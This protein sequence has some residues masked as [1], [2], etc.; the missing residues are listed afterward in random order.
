MRCMRP[1]LV[2]RSHLNLPNLRTFY[3]AKASTFRLNAFGTLSMSSQS[4]P[5]ALTFE[6]KGRCSVSAPIHQ[7]RGSFSDK[8][9]NIDKQSPG[10]G[11]S[12]ASWT[13][14]VTH[15]HASS[16]TRLSQRPHSGA[17]GRYKL[18]TMSQQHLSPWPQARS[19]SPG[20]NRRGAQTSRMDLQYSDR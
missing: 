1:G 20:R 9:P 6:L 4:K 3:T 5:S 15:F 18:Q 13:G 17:T 7:Y 16:Y 10:F 19:S 14:R 12:S 11:P 2:C 8:C